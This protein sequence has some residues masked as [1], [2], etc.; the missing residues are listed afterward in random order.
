MLDF[1]VL[2][3]SVKFLFIL[4]F[5]FFSDFSFYSF[6]YDKILKFFVN[7]YINNGLYKL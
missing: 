3:L 6:S 2:L 7:K 5:R 4:H 1:L